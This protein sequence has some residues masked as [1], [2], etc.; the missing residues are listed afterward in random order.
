MPVAIDVQGK[1]VALSAKPRHR[2]LL[3]RLQETPA[4]PKLAI[5]DTLWTLVAF[6]M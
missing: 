4:V 2:L 1:L 3:S 5:E 6:E